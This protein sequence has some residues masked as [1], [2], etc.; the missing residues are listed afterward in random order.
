MNNNIITGIAIVGLVIAVLVLAFRPA[1]IGG[2]TVPG[3]KNTVSAT[4]IAE[5]KIMPDE[6]SVY[7]TVETLK[8]TADQSKNENTAIS[9][10]V[11]SALKNLDIKDSDIET[12][13]YNIYPEYDWSSGKQKLKGYKAVNSIKV[14][15]TDFN[16]LGKIIDVGVNAG[17]NRI[18][19][20]QFEL[21]TEREAMAKKEALEKASKDAKEKAEA[22]ASGLN[23]KLGKLVSVSTQDYYYQ[24]YR[25]FEGGM[26]MEA[27]AAIGAA[28]QINPQELETRATV[29]VVFELK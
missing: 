27:K 29:N 17:V 23:V 25:F 10:R 12:M 2:G 22:I 26:A 20:I 11:M 21:S 3:E 15:T 18:D 7:L 19:N 28:P 16:L 14:K 9:D 8:D 13:N 1:I 24:P 5:T 4:G 6:A